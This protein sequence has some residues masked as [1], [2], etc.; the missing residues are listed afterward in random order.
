MN[1][2]RCVTPI[3]IVVNKQIVTRTHLNSVDNNSPDEDNI[4]ADEWTE[5]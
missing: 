4:F 3:K 1:N 5:V 2:K